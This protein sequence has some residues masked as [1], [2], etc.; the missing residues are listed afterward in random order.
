MLISRPTVGPS[1][2]AFARSPLPPAVLLTRIADYPI[3]DM[4]VGWR[5]FPAV[6]AVD[7][8]TWDHV[9]AARVHRLADGGQVLET[10]VE[11][12]PGHGFAY[13]LTG[14]TDVFGKLVHGVRGEWSVS[15]DGDGSLAR[16]TW[17]FAPRRFRRTLMALVVGPLWGVYMRRM[18]AAVTAAVSQ[19]PAPRA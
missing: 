8:E 18:I 1:A 5:M 6:T 2:T 9:G 14:F 15:P 16:W 19:E 4:F 3:P 11:H 17:E 12:V 13:E 7:D 10:M